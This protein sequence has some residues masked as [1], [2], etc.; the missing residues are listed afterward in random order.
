MDQI[1]SDATLCLYN[2]GS[3][4]DQDI[5]FFDMELVLKYYIGLM[6]H[7]NLGKLPPLTSPPPTPRTI[8][9][10]EHAK[11]SLVEMF[12]T[13]FKCRVIF[14]KAVAIS[15]L[16]IS[17]YASVIILIDVIMLFF[18]FPQALHLNRKCISQVF[19][20]FLSLQCFIL[21]VVNINFIAL[22]ATYL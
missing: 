1:V 4:K 3:S 19:C 15:F 5:C 12:Y 2:F 17:S 8:L 22:G 10:K 7:I 14:S 16:K 13:T 18:F 6:Q 20:F 9:K 11:D 21:N